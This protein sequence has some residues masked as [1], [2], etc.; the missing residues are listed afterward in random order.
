MKTRIYL[1]TKDIEKLKLVSK[2]SSGEFGKCYKYNDGVLKV[3]FTDVS[4]QVL[5]N[6]NNN[7]KRQ[8]II[9][10]YPKSKLYIEDKFKGYYANMAPGISLESLVLE[11]K[12]KTRDLSFDDYLSIYYDKFL[13]CLI[14]EN[15]IFDDMKLE[16]TFIKDNFYFIDTDLYKKQEESVGLKSA[17]DINLSNLNFFVFNYFIYSFSME[18]FYVPDNFKEDYMERLI[19]SI[20]YKTNYYVDS[21]GKLDSYKF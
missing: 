20:R 7:L 4:K 19:N 5:D 12:N 18:N 3:F 15:V 21:F 2:N 11:I 17:K 1:S 8:S 9:I 16:H 13:P 6:I 14:K 10:M